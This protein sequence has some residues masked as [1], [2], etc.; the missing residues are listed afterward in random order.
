MI[1]R[2]SDRSLKAAPERPRSRTRACDEQAAV[3]KAPVQGWCPGAESRLVVK[4]LIWQENLCAFLA[5]T[6]HPCQRPDVGHRRHRRWVEA[7][8]TTKDRGRRPGV[9]MPSVHLSRL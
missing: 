1:G 5:C 3:P 2:F 6:Q 7:G 4:Q 8:W 9:T